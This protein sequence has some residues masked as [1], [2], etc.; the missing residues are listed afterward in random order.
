MGPVRL[1]ERATPGFRRGRKPGAFVLVLL[2]LSLSAC[3]GPAQQLGPRPGQTPLDAAEAYLQRFQP[4]PNPRVFQTTR[5]LDRRGTPIAELWSEGRR[6]WIPLKRISQHLI[7]ATIAVE[8]STFYIN[9]GV[10]TTRILGAALQNYGEGEVVSGASTITMQLARNLF[11]DPDQRFEQSMD[12]KMLEAGLAQELTNL[13]SKDEILEMY[14]NLANYSHLAYGPEAASQVYFAKSA[15]E[16]T[17]AE[18]TLIAGIPQ[19]PAAFDPFTDLPAVKE[20]QRTVL[21]MMVRHEYLTQAAADAAYR[22]PIVLNPDPDRH[23]NLLPHYVNYVADVL[24]ARLGSGAGTR[25]G[26]T[27]TGTLDVRFQE[28]AQEIVARQVKALQPTHDL[29]NGALVAMLPYSGEILAMVGS[30][31]FNDEKIAGQ[32]NVAR[33]LR[34]PGS[35]IKPVLY[36]AAMDDLLISPATVLWD[37]PVSYPI[38]GTKPYAPVNYDEKFHGPVTVRTAL[39]N[40]YNVPAVKLLEAVTVDRML[41]GAEVMGIRSLSRSEINF[42]LALTLGGGDVTL[43]E[44]TTAYS[45]LASQGRS[46]APEPILQAVDAYGRP[47]LNARRPQGEPL[48]A[49][50][51]S[52][53]FLLTDILADNEARTPMFGANS[54]L[55]LSKPAAAKTGTTDDWRDNWTVGYTRFLV[56]G[57]WTGNSDG[58]PMKR[59]SGIAGAAPIWHEFMEAVLKQPELLAAIGAPDPADDETWRFAAPLDVELL[60][61][62]PPQMRCRKGGEYFSRAW[63]DAAGEAGPLADSVAEVPS[64]PVYALRPDSGRWTAY[65]RTEPAA[66]RGL[67]KLPG[68]LGLPK[69]GEASADTVQ[70]ASG[71]SLHLISYARQDNPTPVPAG[72]S[73]APRQVDVL[74]AVAWSL[75]TP[76]PVD[77]GPCDSLQETVRQ[78]LQAEP[79]QSD[80]SLS[81]SVDLGSAMDPDAGPVAGSLPSPTDNAVPVIGASPGEF[82]FALGEPIQNHSNCPGHYIVGAV[83]AHNGARMG[84]VRIVMVDEWGNRAEAVSKTGASDAGQY[85]F[86]INSFANRYT[87][88]V[89]DSSGSPISVPVTVEHLQGYGGNAPCH[90]VVWQ[91]Y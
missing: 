20:R 2:I 79:K 57:A 70:A 30:A 58:H 40:S 77:L 52:T 74:K 25:S 66:V 84:G 62:C 89:V 34:Q 51:S 50:S 81:I 65:C 44:L 86:P 56:A 54:P 53:A 36:A 22:Q 5:I 32:V 26:L 76:T 9:S 1:F 68:P 4:G 16:L 6:T 75:R 24:D 73:R 10:D 72:G 3:V 23:V 12:R 35:A 59:V 7:D 69:P 18:A 71:A 46:V 78:A 31:D 90:T 83:L 39:A 13:F 33:S 37:I 64:A 41:R 61:A 29:S 19:R 21:D 85:D 80:A 38:T 60:D 88:T 43:L 17:L 45:V 8:D 47:V 28:L 14:L 63:L 91:A 42:G 55:R 48:Q 27:I 67:L 11:L 49:V 82:R 15:S 87:L